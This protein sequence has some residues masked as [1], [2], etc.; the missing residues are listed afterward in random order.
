[1]VQRVFKDQLGQLERQERPVLADRLEVRV[2]RECK[3]PQGQ[4]EQRVQQ[5]VLDPLGLREPRVRQV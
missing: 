4:Q 3:A 5:E 2:P 1:M